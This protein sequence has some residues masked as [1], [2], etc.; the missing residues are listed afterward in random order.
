MKEWREYFGIWHFMLF[1]LIIATSF[2][3]LE[4]EK[5]LKIQVGIGV[6]Y[7][8]IAILA[9]SGIGKI[10]AQLTGG[11]L[12]GY[13]GNPSF[14]AVYLLFNAFFALYFYF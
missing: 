14:F 5:I 3:Y 12:A 4:I 6:L 2:K 1:F 8:L 7:S 9:Y 10:T 13:T 11:R